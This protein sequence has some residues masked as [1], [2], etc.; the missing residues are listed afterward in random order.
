MLP[1][2]SQPGCS[3]GCG[4]NA[5]PLNNLVMVSSH[6]LFE[7]ATDPAVGLACCYAAPLAWYSSSYGEISDE[8]NQA[9]S[10][11]TLADGKQ[12]YVQAQYSN[13]KGL[14]TYS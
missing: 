10:F 13:V 1:D 4:A 5:A 14:C 7:A 12:Y 9:A 3:T 8:C 6:E 2:L 11:K